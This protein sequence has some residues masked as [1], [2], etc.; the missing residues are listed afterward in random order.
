MIATREEWNQVIPQRFHRKVGKLA[1]SVL[2]SRMEE[3][4]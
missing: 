2:F 1:L 3:I 4:I